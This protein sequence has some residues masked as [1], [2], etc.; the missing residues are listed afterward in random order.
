MNN[1]FDSKYQEQPYYPILKAYYDQPMGNDVMVDFHQ[2]IAA[3]IMYVCSGSCKIPFLN[4][5]VTLYQDQMIMINSGVIHG[6]K[7]NIVPNSTMMNIEFIYDDRPQLGPSTCQLTQTYP[8]YRQFFEHQV[9]YIIVSDIRKQIS[10]QIKQV[11]GYAATDNSD[12]KELC[13]MAIQQVLLKIA[14]ITVSSHSNIKEKSQLLVLKT[15]EYINQNF[16]DNIRIGDI[17][18]YLHV[19][20]SY[21]QHL[22]RSITGESINR[23]ILGQR[24]SYAMKLLE[25]TNYPI[26]DVAMEAGFNSQQY[27]AE[28]F[29]DIT[30]KT[31]SQFREKNRVL[32]ETSEKE[33]IGFEISL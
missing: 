20:L 33:E 5:T 6:L 28:R 19:S 24:I 23:Y 27:F 3:E 31:P 18:D 1:L 21:L 29:K 14:A 7:S 17:A 32:S 12:Y 22:F 13:P 9:P 26:I 4:E 16:R 15:Q 8:W 25:R 30:G 10:Y 2:H 11:I